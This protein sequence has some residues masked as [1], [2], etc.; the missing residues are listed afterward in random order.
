MW[1]KMR[2]RHQLVFD[3]IIMDVVDVLDQVIFASYGMLPEPS[4]PDA[5]LAKFF[6]VSRNGAFAAACHK[7]GLSKPFLYARPADGEIC[8]VLRQSPYTMQMVRHKYH[9]QDIE[10]PVRLHLAHCVTQERAGLRI[11]K[12]LQTVMGD[13]RKEECPARLIYATIIRHNVSPVSCRS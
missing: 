9:S 12:D 6:A 13:K 7:P 2:T 3:R 10:R 8:I 1:P 4:L 11:L 5:F